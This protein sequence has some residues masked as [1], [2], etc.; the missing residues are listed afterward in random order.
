MGGGGGG[1]G[2]YSTEHSHW[3][4]GFAIVFGCFSPIKQ[5]SDTLLN[6]ADPDH[7]RTEPGV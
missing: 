2:V 3:D 6:P 1:G 4:S 5:I 7:D